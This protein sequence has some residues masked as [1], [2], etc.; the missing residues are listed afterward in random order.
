MALWTFEEKI[1]LGLNRK[2]KRNVFFILHIE[3]SH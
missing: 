1:F 3:D 2:R